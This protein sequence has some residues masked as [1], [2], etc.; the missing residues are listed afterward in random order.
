MD[1]TRSKEFSGQFLDWVRGKGKVLIVAH[2]NPD[3]DSLAA[4]MALRHLLLNRTGQ[5]ATIAFG[6]VI[7][8]SENRAMFDLL[9]VNAVPLDGLDL[10]QFQIVCLV[11]TQPNTGNNS[12]PS[13][14]TVHLVVDHHPARDVC[15]LCRWS[16]VREDYGASATIL[17]EYLLANDI[18]FGTKLATSLLYAI[19]SETQDLGRDWCRADREAY[20]HLLPL[21]NNRILNQIAHPKVPRSYYAM[22]NRALANARIY[23]DLVVFNLHTIDNPDMVA[24]MAD[25]LLRMEGVSVVLGMGFY[26]GTEILS[27][28][29]ATPELRAGDLIRKV[30]AD[31]GTAGGHGSTAGGQVRG[32]SGDEESQ[33]QLEKDLTERL[34]AQFELSPQQGHALP[35]LLSD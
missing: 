29:T 8:R 26:E 20:L 2:D 6:G 22:F 32:Q 16:D 30:L 34:L 12:L 27:M 23:H 14:R 24:E 33:H 9:E 31:L 10:D 11:D 3:P 19:K 35:V 28:R 15:H 13:D 18:T 17:L 25:F 1:L 7:G 5:V 21:A 4:A